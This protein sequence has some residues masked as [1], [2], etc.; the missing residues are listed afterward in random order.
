MKPLKRTK[1][2]QKRSARAIHRHGHRALP[3]QTLAHPQQGG[4]EAAHRHLR[5]ASAEGHQPRAHRVPQRVARQKRKRL[6]ETL[7]VRIG[8]ANPP[9]PHGKL[10]HVGHA[11][12][13]RPENSN[14]KAAK[15]NGHT[16]GTRG[17]PPGIA[18]KP[19]TLAVVL[20]RPGYS[21][22]NGSNPRPTALRQTGGD[23]DVSHQVPERATDASHG[24][25]SAATESL[26][27]RRNPAV[28]STDANGRPRS[29]AANTQPKIIRKR[30][31]GGKAEVRNNAKADPP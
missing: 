18:A 27:R 8:E 28:R 5:R 24:G 4:R 25:N 21:L 29:R 31:L 22:G 3:R 7:K 13:E 10:R 1:P 30:L 9:A 20:L 23:G 16:S 2:T 12:K 11:D 6:H 14:A 19:K 15:R 26:R 17:D